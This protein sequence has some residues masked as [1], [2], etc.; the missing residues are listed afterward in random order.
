MDRE[1][2]AGVTPLSLDCDGD[3]LH[4]DRGAVFAMRGEFNP[5]ATGL[6]QLPL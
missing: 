6:Q 5:R 2:A 3:Q 4:L 1:I